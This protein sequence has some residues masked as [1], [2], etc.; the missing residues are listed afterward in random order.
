VKAFRLTRKSLAIVLLVAV[1]MVKLPFEE[2]LSNDLRAQKL[3]E[4]PMDVNLVEGLGQMAAAAALGGLRSL[5]AN[6]SYL[7]AYG[8]FEEVRWND[9]DGLMK[10]ATRLD[11]HNTLYWEEASWHMAYNAASFYQRDEKLRP[12]V[13]R[14]LSKEY[15]ERGL[16]D[17]EEGLRF[18]PDNPRLLLRL[19]MIYQ[20]KLNDPRRAAE[21]FFACYEHGGPDYAE[22]MGAYQLT[23]LGDLESTKK[24]YE[25]LKRYYDKGMRKKGTTI[26]EKLPI[27]EERLHIP[28]SQRSKPMENDVLPQVQVKPPQIK[29][30]PG[31]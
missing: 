25:I 19:A 20:D 31:K 15:V 21:A 18:L 6:I 16:Q 1:G 30:A 4:P 12:E 24:A 11:P 3:Q 13:R 8:A 29:P 17:I 2:R 14:R 27:L 5:V 7:M 9:L 28:P 26:M 10:L 23:D 22:R